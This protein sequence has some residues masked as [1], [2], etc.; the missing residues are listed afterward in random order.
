MIN[1][2][3]PKNNNKFINKH[4]LKNNNY[5]NKDSSIKFEFYRPK[6]NNHNTFHSN[7]EPKQYDNFDNK[8]RKSPK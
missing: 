7:I 4:N 8:I 1:I 5:D 2:K 6:D 3:S